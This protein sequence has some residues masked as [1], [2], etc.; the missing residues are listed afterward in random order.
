[1][2][3]PLVI[4][5]SFGVLF[6]YII[7]YAITPFGENNIVDIKNIGVASVL[8][9]ITTAAL[10]TFLHLIL[11][12]LFFRKFYEK[13]RMMLALRR[14]ILFALFLDAL[15]WIRIFGFWM[16]HVIVL[17]FALVILVEA[18][19]MALTPSKH[20]VSTSREEDSRRN[21]P[22]REP[23]RAAQRMKTHEA[24]K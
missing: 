6:F 5:L 16:V 14:G 20:K 22:R 17:T 19:F 21:E 18:L 2:I 8:F 3:Y 9:V 23:G 24:S 12:K 7:N 1:M 15:V 4:A 13:P 10:F 11:D